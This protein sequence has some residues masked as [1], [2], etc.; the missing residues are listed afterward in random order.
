LNQ[1]YENKCRIEA[2]VK[3]KK[4]FRKFGI[5]ITTLAS[6]LSLSDD[7]K[8][9]IICSALMAHLEPRTR[10]TRANDK[11]KPDDHVIYT[12]VVGMMGHGNSYESI[13][14]LVTDGIENKT[15]R[16]RTQ[17]KIDRIYN[18]HILGSKVDKTTKQ[19]D[20]VFDIIG[21]K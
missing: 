13:R 21:W 10:M 16:N 15:A 3:N 17:K 14:Y 12:L 20:I 7:V 1:D 5:T 2:T 18:E 19:I 11:L 8:Q 4:H 9:D 6:I